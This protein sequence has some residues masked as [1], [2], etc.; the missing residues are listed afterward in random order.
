MATT[1]LSVPEIHCDHCKAAVEGA[2]GPLDGVDGVEVDVPTATVRIDHDDVLDLRR[3]VD[4][5]EDQGY[6]VPE[7]DALDR[8]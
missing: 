1:M 8:T 2:V 4:V 3:V 6:D 5:I 7:Q